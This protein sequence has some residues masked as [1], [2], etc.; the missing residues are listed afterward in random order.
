MARLVLIAPL[1]ALLGGCIIY[2]THPCK[3][4]DCRDD[5][6]AD[7]T[8]P[9]VDRPDDDPTDTDAPADDSG[10]AGET[11]TFVLDPGVAAP[12]D[13]FIASLTAVGGI[14]YA[15]IEGVELYGEATLLAA[16]VRDDEV[17][18]SITVADDAVAGGV[19]LLVLRV[20]GSVDFVESALLIQVAADGSG[21]GSGD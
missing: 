18:L 13:T 6:W 1:A 19:D 11:A 10:D 15:T 5:D 3:G 7:D 17:L 21:D 14:D 8:G 4:A 16:D 20:D 12:G 9:D 2:D